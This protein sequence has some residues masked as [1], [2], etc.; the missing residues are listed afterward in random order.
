MAAAT[1]IGALRRFLPDFL[2]LHPVQGRARRRAIWA[3]TH[4]RTEVM[5]GHVHACAQCGTSRFAFHSCNHRACPQCG[6][7][8]TAQWVERELGKRVGAPYFMV[9]FTLPEELRALFFTK[10]A[11]QVHEVFFAAASE[12]LSSTLSSPR[13]LGAERSGFT[14]ILHTWNQRLLF[15]PHIHCI[16]PGAG[17]DAAGRVVSVRS[18]GFLVPQP[19]L[20]SAFRQLFAHKLHALRRLRPEDPLPAVDP[21]VWTKDWGVHLQPFGDGRRAIQYL[22]AYVCRTAIA[23]SR[24]LSI[25][26]TGVT[27]SWKDRAHGNAMRVEKVSGIEF[28]RRYL[29]HVLPMGMRAIRRYGFCH[30]VARAKRERIAF[31]TG[32]PIVLGPAEPPPQKPGPLCPCCGTK[33]IPLMRLPACWNFGRAPP[34]THCRRA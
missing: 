19:V 20:R 4:C 29:R 24:I 23:D 31:H 32:C 10:A 12:A 26:E 5:G 8:A 21:G 3:L 1:V 13:W 25:D 11:R 22:G 30:P 27:F 9:T 16:V 18:P 7:E 6:R 14:M 28:V 15:H 17:I 34:A 33:M 2:R